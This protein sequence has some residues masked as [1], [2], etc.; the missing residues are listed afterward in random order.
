MHAVFSLCCIEHKTPTFQAALWGLEHQPLR[1][2]LEVEAADLVIKL[3][4]G[5][6]LLQHQNPTEQKSPVNSS[7]V[8]I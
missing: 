7:G 3:V 2:S 6:A 8:R 4:G 1:T 5:T